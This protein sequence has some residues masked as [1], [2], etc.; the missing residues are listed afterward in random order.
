MPSNF[1]DV[2][3]LVIENFHKGLLRHESDFPD[4]PIL[5]NLINFR[6]FK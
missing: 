5:L 3:A 1:V 4:F 6:N 2:L